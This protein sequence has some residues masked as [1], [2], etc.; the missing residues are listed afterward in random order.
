MRTTAITI[1]ALCTVQLARAQQQLPVKTLD[2]V[3]VKAARKTFGITR[4]KDV[5]GAGIYSGKKSEVIVLKDITA[6]TATNNSRQIYSRVAGL[7]IYENDGGAG[8]QLAIGGRG[9]DPNRVSNFNTRQNGYDISADALGYP[10]S[11]YTPPTEAL[12]KIEIVRGA[13]SLQYG[14]QFGGIINFKMN[15]GVDSQKAQIVSRLS[16]GSWNFFNTS[17][18]VGGTVNKLNY[19]A[20]IQHKS[21]DGWRANSQFNSNTA[22]I[23]GTLKASSKLAI[24]AE[25][26][27]MDY[28]EHQPGGLSDL[29]FAENPDSSTKKRNWFK[30]NWN[31]GALLI[32]YNITKNLKLNSRFFGLSAE[33]SA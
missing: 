28:L 20:F 8:T 22:Y 18:S 13:A 32:D 7:N 24:T 10:E 3:K 11:Y 9:L 27:H 19:Y 5:D 12:E 33:R 26:T 25:Y 16:A 15:S 1:L 2:S 29:M 21:G 30:V 23:S 6:N 14:T 17:T 4:L 31:L